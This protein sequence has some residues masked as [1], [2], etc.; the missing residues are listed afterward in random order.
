M[1]TSQCYCPPGW[2]QHPAWLEPP[3]HGWA[4]AW[5]TTVPMQ[6]PSVASLH[7]LV[8]LVGQDLG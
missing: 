1:P 6:R 2:G 7:V 4:G 8:L 3:V 5:L